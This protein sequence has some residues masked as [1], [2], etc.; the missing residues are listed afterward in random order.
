MEKLEL[1]EM[2]G[3]TKRK[4]LL[5]Q[6]NLLQKRIEKAREY[7]DRPYNEGWKGEKLEQGIKERE[8]HVPELQKLFKEQSEC[9]KKLSQL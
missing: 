8:R 7:M 1:F 2:M 3:R 6:F 4:Q 5:T 9:L